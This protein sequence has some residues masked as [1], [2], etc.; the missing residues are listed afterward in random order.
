MKRTPEFPPLFLCLKAAVFILGSQRH[1]I[2]FQFMFA[3]TF[4]LSAVGIWYLL[5]KKS[6]LFLKLTSILLWPSLRFL[7]F[8]LQRT[9]IGHL[10]C[11]INWH[12]TMITGSLIMET[13]PNLQSFRTHFFSTA[14]VLIL[15]G[16]CYGKPGMFHPL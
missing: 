13:D 4:I 11:F 10:S 3:I 16:G 7:V 6:F 5:R 8:S 9:G 2:L 15:S 12:L 14:G 1:F